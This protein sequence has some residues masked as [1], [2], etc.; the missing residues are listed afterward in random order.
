MLV[1]ADPDNDFFK[2]LLS[3]P[4]AGDFLA[5][6]LPPRITSFCSEKNFGVYL[7]S[8]SGGYC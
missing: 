7:V 5:C 2:G 3:R 6:Y 4:G 1:P 8:I